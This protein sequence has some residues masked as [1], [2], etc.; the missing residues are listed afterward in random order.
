MGLFLFW[1]R[2]RVKIEFF[3]LNF[4]MGFESIFGDH[5]V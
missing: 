1:V 5:V 3:C 2:M 4:Y